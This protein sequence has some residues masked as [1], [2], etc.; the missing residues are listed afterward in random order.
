[1]AM[2]PTTSFSP[3]VTVLNEIDRALAKQCS[4]WPTVVSKLIQDYQTPPVEYSTR[5]IRKYGGKDQR[6][7][8]VDVAHHAAHVYNCRVWEQQQQILDLLR[9]FTIS[10]SLQS[11]AIEEQ[12][13]VSLAASHLLN[14]IVIHLIVCFAPTNFPPFEVAECYTSPLT[15]IFRDDDD[16]HY[17]NF[18]VGCHSVAHHR[19]QQARVWPTHDRKFDSATLRDPTWAG[20]R[21]SIYEYITWKDI[22]TESRLL[23]QIALRGATHAQHSDFALDVRAPTVVPWGQWVMK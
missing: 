17:L 15:F 19:Q 16:L 10:S 22:A 8:P 2:L 5:L 12:N 11:W 23:R 4:N 7:T 21:T 13:V 1:M 20:L 6:V 9:R 14:S 3:L 18:V